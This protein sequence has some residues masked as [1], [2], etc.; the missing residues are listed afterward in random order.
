MIS[1]KMAALVAASLI[2]SSS[3]ATAQSA[4]PL[5]LTNSPMVQ[6]AGHNFQGRS[7]LDRRG[8]GIY[9]VGAIVLGL[10]AWGIYELVKSKSP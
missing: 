8:Y 4:R 6:R 2:S 10:A 7:D 1:R 3:A 9:I 5:S